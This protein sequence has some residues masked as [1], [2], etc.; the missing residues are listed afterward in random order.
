MVTVQLRRANGLDRPGL[1]LEANQR[2]I[3]EPGNSGKKSALPAVKN[4]LADLLE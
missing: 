4:I 1:K 2:E 3:Y